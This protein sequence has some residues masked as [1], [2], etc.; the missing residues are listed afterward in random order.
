M[1][2]NHGSDEGNYTMNSFCGDFSMRTI[3]S[4]S[5]YISHFSIKLIKKRKDKMGCKTARYEL[6]TIRSVPNLFLLIILNAMKMHTKK[7]TYYRIRIA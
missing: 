5:I 3:I 2:S 6:T 7:I 4:V 1:Q